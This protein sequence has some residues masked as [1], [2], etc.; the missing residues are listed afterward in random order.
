MQAPFAQQS[1]LLLI[2]TLSFVLSLGVFLFFLSSNGAQ[3]E[4]GVVNTYTA[5]QVIVE[6]NNRRTQEG[7]P[8][9][10]LNTKLTKAAGQKADHM[11]EYSYFSHIHPET[12][13][14]WSDFIKESDY[15][16]SVAGENLANGFYTVSEMVD[17]WVASPTHRENI[18]NKN[19]SETGVGIRKGQLN[20]NPT[21]YVVQVFG[22]E[23]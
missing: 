5:D 18:V 8:E 21:I 1:K 13:K 4:A 7:L 22:K 9:L 14:K 6:V 19:V 20:G 12:G 2:S 15:T 23:E 17:A 10:V 16:Y 11:V 3:A